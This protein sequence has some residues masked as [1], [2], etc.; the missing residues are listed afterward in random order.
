MAV[1]GYIRKHS[2]IAVILVGISLVAF[3]VG[4]NLIDWARNVLGYS[5]GPGSKREIG[6][7]NGQSIS[8]AEFEG[9]TQK[10]VELTKLNQQKTELSADE[11]FDIKNQTWAQRVKEMIMQEEYDKLGISVTD[12]EMIELLRGRDPHRLI[13]QYFVNENGVYDPNLVVGYMQNIDQLQPQ[14]RI[15]WENFKEYIY[16]DRLSTKYNALMSQGFY[17]P[18]ALAEID[19]HNNSDIY[20]ARYV[21]LNYDVLPDSLVPEP[22]ESQKEDIYDKIKNQYVTTKTRDIEYVVFNILPS[23]KDLEEIREETNEIFEEWIHSSN[24]G[25][26]VNNVPGN[27]Y[28]SSW[29]AAGELPVRIDSLMFAEEIGTFVEPY[30]DGSSWFMA[31]LMEKDVRPDSASAEHVLIAYQGAFRS[32]PELTRSKEDAERLA[33]SIYN[34]LR[35]DVNKFEEIAIE[36]SDDGSVVN[37]NGNLGWFRDGFM[38]HSFNDAVIKGKKGDVVLVETVF[39][40]HVIHITDIS[41]AKEKVRVAMI[42]VPIEYSSETYDSY[43]AMARKFAGENNTKEKFDQ[44]VIDEGLEKRE[45]RYLREMQRDIPT[46][47]NTRQIIRWVFW[48]DRE[49]GDVSSLFD[50][51][52]KLLVVSYVGGTEP[53]DYISME[54]ISDHLNLRAINENKANYYRE[55]ADELATND[56]YAIA[57]TFDTKVD[58]VDNMTFTS[59][60]LPGFGTE[61]N[62]LGQM[63][64]MNEGET[65]DAL[66]G[67][68]A[69]FFIELDKISKAPALDNYSTYS[70]RKR[71]NFNSYINNNY[72]YNSLEKNADIKDYRRYFY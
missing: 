34:V 14:D 18:K 56:I 7:V 32:D 46:L 41:P 27:R 1:I 25:E 44:A 40:F 6:I 62:V 23:E 5:S 9:L 26:F 59:R 2:A 22:T 30:K 37:N 57:Q 17:Y 3:L 13:R 12:D 36:L 10:N 45:A 53:S 42:E 38:V 67:N 70:N 64:A 4:P 48:D 65:S 8:L 69:L 51:G 49:V 39:G 68:G 52:G 29:Y 71:T 58:T 72:M 66:E 31:R 24:P 16:N 21:G 60:N 33:D 47:E 20:T 43:Y 19:Y 15:Q 61:N 35:R 54:Q 50:I 55:K 28:D 63:F 11:I